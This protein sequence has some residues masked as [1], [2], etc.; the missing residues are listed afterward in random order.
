MTHVLRQAVKAVAV[1]T[2]ALSGA[3]TFA[4]SVHADVASAVA[5]DILFGNAQIS[6]YAWSEPNAASRLEMRTT[7]QSA[8]YHSRD[9]WAALQSSTDPALDSENR[10][11]QNISL[12]TITEARGTAYRW[13]IRSTPEQNAY[14]WGI[15]STPEQ[16]AY[17]WGIRSTP[18]Q[19]AYRWGIRAF[20][21]GVE[22]IPQR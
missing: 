18:E 16:N 9:A 4:T 1:A 3:H 21:S 2:L 6:G 19:N 12:E 5:K 11:R 20:C 14:R 17:R 22:R 13:G 8:N 10:E 15:R 7:T